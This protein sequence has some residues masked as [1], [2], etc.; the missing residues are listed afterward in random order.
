MSAIKAD[1]T[2][3]LRYKRPVLASLGYDALQDELGKIEDACFNIHWFMEQDDDTLINALDGDE[4][5]AFEFQVAFADLESKIYQIQEAME[6]NWCWAEGYTQMYDDCT[7][8][9]IGNRFQM[10]GW[11][12][13]EEDYFS[14]TQYEQSLAQSEAGRRLMRLK[15]ADMISTIGQCLGTLIAFLDIRQQYDYLKATFDILRDENTSL[16]QTI[17]E[18]DAAYEAADSVGWHNCYTEVKQFQRLLETLPE[19][20]WIE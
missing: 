20:V 6:E 2:R 8:A 13:A 1:R 5:Q 18:I 15:K 3:N 16:L 10:I 9:L 19:R 7:V 12:D 14:L 17:K 11:D 4:E